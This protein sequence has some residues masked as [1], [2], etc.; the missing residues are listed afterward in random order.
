MLMERLMLQNNGMFDEKDISSINKCRLYLQ[1]IT[2][3]D[4]GT[5][6][7]KSI[8]NKALFGTKDKGRK[9]KWTW[10]RQN[11]PPEHEWDIWIQCV[12]YIW[13]IPN[14]HYRCNIRLGAW[15]NET[16]Q[17]FSWWYSSSMNALYYST[18]EKWFKYTSQNSDNCISRKKTFFKDSEVRIVLRD[19]QASK[20]K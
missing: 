14:S 16:H 11:R 19:I 15:T 6:D 18:K 5:G 2:L 4:I 13:C 12:N 7:G 10:P 20:V 17:Q 3:A 1:V 9:S 8:S